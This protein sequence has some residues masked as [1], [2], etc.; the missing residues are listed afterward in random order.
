MNDEVVG[1]IPT[2]G[3]GKWQLAEFSL[4]D[5]NKGIFRFEALAPKDWAGGKNLRQNWLFPVIHKIILSFFLFCA[6][7]LYN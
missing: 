4:G 5:P 1:S 7:K 2:N 6:G 3:S